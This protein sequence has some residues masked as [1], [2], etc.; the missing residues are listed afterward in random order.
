[1]RYFIVQYEGRLG[2][3]LFRGNLSFDHEN[4]PNRGVLTKELEEMY[5]YHSIC[6]TDLKELN[7]EDY[8]NWNSEIV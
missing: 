7:L 3:S 1:M 4:Y 6:I 5:G 2:D 8:K